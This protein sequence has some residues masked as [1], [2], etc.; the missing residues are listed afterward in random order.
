MMFRAILIQVCLVMALGQSLAQSS[1]LEEKGDTLSPS[2]QADSSDT[3][4]LRKYAPR[5]FLDCVFCDKKYLKTEIT[6]VNYVRERKEAQVHILVRSEPTGSGGTKYTVC[7][8]GQQEFADLDNEIE[9]ITKSNVT[10]EETRTGFAR[11]LKMGLMPYVA[12]TPLANHINVSYEVPSVPTS[13]E[14]RW[15]SWVFAI[16]VSGWMN[17]QQQSRN[18]N[19]FGNVSASRITTEYKI[20]LSAHGNYSE[21][22]FEIG[23]EKITSVSEGGGFHGNNVFS[24]TEHWSAGGM[25][26]VGSNTYSNARLAVST[27]PSIEYNIFPYSESTKRLLLCNYSASVCY[28]DY[29]EETIY[30]KM[31]EQLTRE[32][33]SISYSTTQTWGSISASLSGSHYFHDFSKNRFTLSASPSLRL[34]KG[35]SLTL[36]GWWSM[37]HN[38]LSLPADGATG[39]EVLL[40]RKELATQ[41]RFWAH[42]SVS[43]TFGSIYSNVVNPRMG[44]W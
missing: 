18:F 41:F 37:I 20:S 21:D 9:Y 35:F 8:M 6:F 28:N 4:N 24:L 1:E 43:Y 10:E 7:F 44:Y 39:E 29:F 2:V 16:E 15:K 26:Y 19:S 14:D 32:S 13:V 11:V 34:F 33:L 27:G 30:G 12:R 22:Y 23:D 42:V 40:R 31:S 25:A 5:V 3:T 36:N 17:G 38:Q